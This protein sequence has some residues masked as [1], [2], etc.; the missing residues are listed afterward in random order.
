MRFTMQWTWFVVAHGLVAGVATAQ[1][2][3]HSTVPDAEAWAEGIGTA[4]ANLFGVP[5]LASAIATGQV[6]IYPGMPPEGT[7]A[8][9][10]TAPGQPPKIIVA[11]TPDGQAAGLGILHEWHHVQMQHLA[12]GQTGWTDQI[13]ACQEQQAHCE[14]ARAIAEL[15]NEY[16]IKVKCAIKNKIMQDALNEYFKCV[17]YGPFLENPCAVALSAIPCNP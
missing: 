17:G 13:A 4:A 3:P 5:S 14:V 9:T 1:G 8:V 7:A 2:I 6:N 11:W 10:A 16:G 12:Y 15:F